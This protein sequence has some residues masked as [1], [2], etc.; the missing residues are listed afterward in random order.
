MATHCRG[1]SPNETGGTK[2]KTERGNRINRKQR[3]E[4][5]VGCKVIFLNFSKNVKKA[6]E[7]AP[8]PNRRGGKGKKREVPRGEHY[9][10][11]VEAMCGAPSRA[12]SF[13]LKGEIKRKKKKKKK[14]GQQK[15]GKEGQR[16]GGKKLFG[17]PTGA[18]YSQ[19]N[20]G[21]F[22]PREKQLLG[23][24]ERFGRGP[25]GGKLRKNT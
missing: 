22:S 10:R 17:L 6:L 1:T 25:G 20:I 7:K 23:Q 16:N 21:F 19:R 18:R 15:D 5:L 8:R 3:N 9:E 4:K 2:K 24:E 14:G 12:R 11:F 13:V